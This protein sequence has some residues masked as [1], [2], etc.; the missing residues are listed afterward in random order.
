MS[1]L[2]PPP[3]THGFMDFML[4]MG[5]AG[6][7]AKADYVGS[8]DLFH[9]MGAYFTWHPREHPREQVPVGQVPLHRRPGP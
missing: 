5:V 1:P 8:L 7:G 4:M 3:P 2:P 6:E 9:T